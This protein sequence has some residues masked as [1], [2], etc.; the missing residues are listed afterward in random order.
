MSHLAFSPQPPSLSAPRCRLF[1][2]VLILLMLG[3]L[4]V[5]C[6]AQEVHAAGADAVHAADAPPAEHPG[7]TP[8][9]PRF[10]L[11]PFMV[12]NSMIVTWLVAVG[13]IIFARYATQRMKDV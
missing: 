13:I 5:T 7:L 1:S 11:G 8:D 3:G 4:S 12:T 9:A 6:F 2:L 10:R